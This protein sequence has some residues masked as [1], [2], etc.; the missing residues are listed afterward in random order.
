[1]KNVFSFFML[2]A[3]ISFLGFVVENLWTAATKGFMDNKNMT[4]PFLLGYG[5][6]VAMMY[7]LFGLPREMRIGA[8][9][10]NFESEG[11][12]IICYFAMI[13][14]CICIGEIILGFAVE[15]ICGI[16]W[17][18]YTALPLHITKYTSIPTSAGFT[19]IIVH[20]MDNVF[21]PL[22]RFFSSWNTAALGTV[23]VTLMLLMA[24]DFIRSG[25][26]MYKNRALLVTWRRETTKN[27]VYRALH[28]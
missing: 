24:A 15:K 11:A 21:M 3:L 18:N 8:L 23:A 25:W 26:L 19:L 27:R 14:L 16:E 6:A 7:L 17:W 20:F 10:L 4:L 5:L 9:R 22:F 28:K 1:M 2:I 12:S 13:M